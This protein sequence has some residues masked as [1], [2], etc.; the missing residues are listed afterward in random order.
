MYSVKVNGVIIS[1]DFRTI[2]EAKEWIQL[3]T[4]GKHNAQIVKQ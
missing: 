1:K 3:R 4:H 2:Q